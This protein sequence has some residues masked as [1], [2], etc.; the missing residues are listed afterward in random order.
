MGI[1][2]IRELLFNILVETLITNNPAPFKKK[3]V[4]L[5]VSHIYIHFVKII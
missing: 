1:V 2:K 4:F 5:P 3:K